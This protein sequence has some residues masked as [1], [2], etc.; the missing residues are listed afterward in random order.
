MRDGV[1][2]GGD[3]ILVQV[4]A[5]PG[6]ARLD[7]TGLH[8][9]VL[10]DSVQ[11]AYNIVRS[12]FREFGINEKLLRE[13]VIAVHLVRIAEPKEGPSAGLAF[14]VGIVS[15]L[16]GRPVRPGCAV[17]GEVSLFGDIT[18]VGGLSFKIRAAAKA[19]RKLVLVPAE[20]A[21][22]VAQ[23]PDE[24]LSRLEVVP[25]RTIQEALLRVLDEPGATP[26][27]NPL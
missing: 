9:Q 16:T 4:S 26:P 23:V 5:F 2:V 7:V 15:A 21:R 14:V 12:R 8:G 22:E 20:N 18:G 11:T 25:V 13:R 19:G 10:R 6:Y 17:T 24:V 1:A 3:L 27:V